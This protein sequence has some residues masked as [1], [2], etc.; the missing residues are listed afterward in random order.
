MQVTNEEGK[1]CTKAPAD[2]LES[3]LCSLG[4][5]D[6]LDLYKPVFEDV[7]QLK[8]VADPKASVVVITWRFHPDSVRALKALT[9]QTEPACEVVLV[10]NGSPE[11]EL[12]P[13]L[14]FVHTLVRLNE[15]T[16]AYL[17][18]NVGALFAQAP[19][20]IFLDDDGIPDKHFV[21]E[22]LKAHATYGIVAARGAV[23]PKTDNPLNAQA[24][25]YNLGSSP[26][27]IFADVE[28]NSSYRGPAFFAVGGWD[29]SIRFGG[30]GVELALRL[31][32]AFPDW[33]NQIYWPAATIQHD[34]SATQET[35]EAKRAK[36]EASRRAMEEKQPGY[37]I[38]IEAWRNPRGKAESIAPVSTN[39][40]PLTDWRKRTMAQTMV[41]AD[42]TMG[43]RLQ[44][45][46]D[47][48]T[49][50]AM[51]QRARLWLKNK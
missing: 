47:R 11:G 40:Q 30:G 10:D 50:M 48:L 41:E 29:D 49:A 39:L 19:A 8:T 15:N 1:N 5:E 33:G 43:R 24:L 45:T 32:R 51:L 37:R 21:E 46:G 36:Q 3:R 28:G 25:H 9:R 44:A 22:H 20:L 42:L 26:F 35:L 2:L 38:V 17:A 18:R 6:K 23:L 7:Q 13:L 12:A 27:P 31:L 16:G 14:P 4:W 34:Y